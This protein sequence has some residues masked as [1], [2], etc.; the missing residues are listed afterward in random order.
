MARVSR[1]LVRR[2][3]QPESLAELVLVKHHRAMKLED[4]VDIE[5]FT[6]SVTPP[7]KIA[8]RN[9][10]YTAIEVGPESYGDIATLLQIYME[11]PEAELRSEQFI[12]FVEDLLQAMPTDENRKT[13]IR[14][15]ALPFRRFELSSGTHRLNV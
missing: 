3:R 10:S 15:E 8:F 1:R 7:R 6:D 2:S 14:A 12:F 11:I 9:W 5:R 13:L 4:L